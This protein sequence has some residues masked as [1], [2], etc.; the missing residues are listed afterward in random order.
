MYSYKRSMVQRATSVPS[1]RSWRHTLSEAGRHPAQRGHRRAPAPGARDGGRVRRRL[2]RPG[3]PTAH[4]A[5]GRRL[6]VDHEP[7]QFGDGTMAMTV[8]VGALVGMSAPTLA[9]VEL[10]EAAG[11]VLLAFARGDGFV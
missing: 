2:V 7:R 4:R 10:V 3:R 6:H 11:M 8:G 5:R 1:R 9:A